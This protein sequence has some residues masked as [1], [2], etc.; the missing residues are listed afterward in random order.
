MLYL[1]AEI[2]VLTEFLEAFFENF[3]PA[4]V[5]FCL[6][7]ERILSSYRLRFDFFTL[8]QEAHGK[9]FVASRNKV[10]SKINSVRGC[11]SRLSVSK[12]LVMSFPVFLLP[13]IRRDLSVELTR[14]GVAFAIF[15]TKL[16]AKFPSVAHFVPHFVVRDAHCGLVFI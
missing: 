7:S 6:K 11:R 10:L 8:L 15:V 5:P 13:A 12:V 1:L 4:E 3:R 2:A 9:Y 14:I 16:Q